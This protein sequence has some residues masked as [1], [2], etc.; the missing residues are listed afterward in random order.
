MGP[1]LDCWFDPS[2][3]PWATGDTDAAFSALQALWLPAL[4]WTLWERGLRSI[5]GHP[6]VSTLCLPDLTHVIRSA[7]P[8]PSRGERTM[9]TICKY[10]LIAAKMAVRFAMSAAWSEMLHDNNQY[11]HL[12]DSH[13]CGFWS[14]TFTACPVH[15]H[16]HAYLPSQF[17]ATSY[18]VHVG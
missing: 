5:I 15:V 3:E 16:I 1:V 17:K 14:S 10:S 12:C 13:M 11:S 7:R 18:L 6:H 4:G 8:S 2:P 9:Q